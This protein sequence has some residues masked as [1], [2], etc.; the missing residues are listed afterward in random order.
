[1]LVLLPRL[2]DMTPIAISHAILRIHCVD[3][4]ITNVIWDDPIRR[5]CRHIAATNKRFKVSISIGIIAVWV[6]H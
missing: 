3:I 1:M 6:I 2:L 4:E 5:G